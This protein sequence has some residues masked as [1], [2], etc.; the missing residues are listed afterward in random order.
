[1]DCNENFGPHSKHWHFPF[2]F[3]CDFSGIMN[4]VNKWMGQWTKKFEGWVPYDIEEKD[5]NYFIVMPLPGLTKEE[6]DV[7]LIG[8]ELNIKTKKK[9][10]E[11][12]ETK[13]EKE[14]KKNL[15]RGH[16]FLR[17]FL[18]MLW[19]KGV[20]MDIQIPD[21]ADEN[22]IKSIMANGLLKIKFG[23]KPSKRVDINVE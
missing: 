4:D 12:N 5:D 11:E 3:G 19:K 10:P 9:T 16:G 18:N 23:K 8:R 15:Y 7:S 20:D 6:V 14:S 1:M 2:S 17:Y 22:S 21:D 13:D